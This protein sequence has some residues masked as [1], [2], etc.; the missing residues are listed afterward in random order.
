[1]K[2]KVKSLLAVGA[3]ALSLCS[4]IEAYADTGA[5]QQYTRA[6]EAALSANN[7]GVAEKNFTLALSEAERSG[8][9]DMS[10][11][12]SLENLANLYGARGQFAKV[13]PLLERQLRVKEKL[14]GSE[15]SEV[16]SQVGKLTVF[17]LTHGTAGKAD[18]LSNLLLAFADKKVKEQQ[19]LA[20]HLNWLGQLFARQ[21]EWAESGNLL[22]RVE[23]ATHKACANQ[24]LEL[25]ASLDALGNLY[26]QR[27]KYALSERLFKNALALRQKTLSAGHLALAYSYE[28]LGNLYVAQ[29]KNDLAEPFFKQALDVTEKTLQPQR[30]EVYTRLDNLARSYVSLGQYAEA[31]SLYK[32]ALAV[33]EKSGTSGRDLSA[34][35]LALAQLY[36]KQG[37]LAPAE[38]L[39]KRGLSIVEAANG[40]QHA[41]LVPV[42][43]TYADVLEKNNHAPEAARARA[44]ARAIQGIAA[45]SAAGPSGSDF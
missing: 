33:M 10:L 23:E 7:Y 38:P 43:E 25:S 22:K 30:P 34:V 37:K 41:C 6:G 3:L 1:M 12:R 5:W 15:S 26:K 24:H 19:A 39:L 28:N 2:P 11:C 44:R 9:K 29:G 27:G 31:E 18:R 35:C 36:I 4:P 45:T 13:E 42:L 14:L 17:Y 20:D 8:A 40:P 16:V 21:P 32:R